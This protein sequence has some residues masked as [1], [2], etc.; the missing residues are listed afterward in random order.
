MK[1]E[2]RKLRKSDMGEGKV[3]FDRQLG[4]Q[5]LFCKISMCGIRKETKQEV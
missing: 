4:Y 5:K 2:Y 3:L 1:E